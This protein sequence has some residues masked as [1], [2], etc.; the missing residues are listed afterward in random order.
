MVESNADELAGAAMETFE[1]FEETVEEEV[2]KALKEAEGMAK[3]FAPVDTGFMRDNISADLEKDV[4]RS[5][6]DYS[7]FQEFGTIHHPPQP[8]MR[9]ATR[10]ALTASIRRLE[11]IE[12]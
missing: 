11:A 5:P 8:F 10:E 7:S 9:P 12:Q 2:D 1:A 3:T 6:A 4:L